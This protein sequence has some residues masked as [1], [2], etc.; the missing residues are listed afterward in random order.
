MTWIIAMCI[1]LHGRGDVLGQNVALEIVRRWRLCSPLRTI[2]LLFLAL[3]IW[4]QL[5]GSN[6]LVTLFWR[7][8]KL[9]V[10]SRLQVQSFVRSCRTHVSFPTSAG[11]YLVGHV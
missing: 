4:Q 2:A 8:I 6:C 10:H 1:V 9:S 5:F 3:G 11:G 7:P